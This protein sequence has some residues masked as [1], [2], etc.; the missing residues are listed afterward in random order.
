MREIKKCILVLLLVALIGYMV[1]D[2]NAANKE[3]VRVE[4]SFN[5]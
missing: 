1:V 3:E 5:F 2:L 4:S